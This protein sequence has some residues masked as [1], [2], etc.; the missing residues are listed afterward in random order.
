MKKVLLAIL[1]VMISV[2]AFAD[3][4]DRNGRGDRRDDRRGDRR[5]D[6][7]RD[8][9]NI[10]DILVPVIVGGGYGPI[11]YRNTIR[12]ESINNQTRY[13]FAGLRQVTHVSVVRQLSNSPCINRNN[14]GY[15]TFT[16]VGGNVVVRN[17]CRAIFAV[18]GY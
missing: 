3:A 13:C 14:R 6:D 11:P 17:G 7:H 9:R 10:W 12:C 18:H 5:H 16:A 1:A 8:H 2:S 15:T 4:G